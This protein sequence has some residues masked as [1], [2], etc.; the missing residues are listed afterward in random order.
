M[1]FRDW[2]KATEI[3]ATENGVYIELT[4]SEILEVLVE[5]YEAKR[6]GES[7]ILIS[8]KEFEVLREV[9]KNSLVDW[10]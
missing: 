2:I 6:I 9:Y 7:K 3:T 10:S 1:N 4:D 8:V 5:D